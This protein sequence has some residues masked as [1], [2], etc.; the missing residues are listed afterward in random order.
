MFLTQDKIDTLPADTPYVYLSNDKFKNRSFI[1][2]HRN[3]MIHYMLDGLQM[4]LSDSDGSFILNN[5][6]KAMIERRSR[7][8][9][10]SDD[11]Y[12]WIN[13]V[14]DL[15]EDD[16]D[17]VLCKDV[18]AS[19]KTSDL[20]M[21]LNKSEKRRSN[22]SHII[23]EIRSHGTLSAYYRASAKRIVPVRVCKNKH[24]L[25]RHKLKSV[26]QTIGTMLGYDV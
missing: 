7:Y 2:E 22:K 6:P 11:F 19:Y 18:Y 16:K 8:V 20:Y 12:M 5:L 14:Y 9:Q 3:A 23:D 24:I 17:I 26:S 10:K 4:L 1:G 13:E 25:I 15:T 21:N